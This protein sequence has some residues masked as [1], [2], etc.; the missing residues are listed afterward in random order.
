VKSSLQL[1]QRQNTY[2]TPDAAHGHRRCF[3]ELVRSSLY[4]TLS[5]VG[6]LSGRSGGRSGLVSYNFYGYIYSIFYT[7][8]ETQA[9][10]GV[11]VTLTVA[12]LLVL[13]GL[14]PRFQGAL[15]PQFVVE[16]QLLV[17]QRS[18]GNEHCGA[19]RR[20]SLGRWAE[21]KRGYVGIKGITPAQ[22]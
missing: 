14:I 16:P 12:F 4:T 1:Q 2:L 9:I 5:S 3:V 10:S 20:L 22:I 7:V 13:H 17:V 15:W 8:D 6:V 18:A 19:F 21:T 11:L